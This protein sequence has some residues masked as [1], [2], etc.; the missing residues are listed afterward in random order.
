MSA[1]LA[2]VSLRKT[3]APL[4]RS[5]HIASHIKQQRNGKLASSGR[6]GTP[7]KCGATILDLP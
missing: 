7:L 3:L 6:I 5:L 1:K 2:H 4:L